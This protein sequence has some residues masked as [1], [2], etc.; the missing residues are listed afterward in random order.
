[1]MPSPLEGDRSQI[2]KALCLKSIDV[3][4]WLDTLTTKQLENFNNYIKECAKTGNLSSMTNGHVEFIK[5]FEALTA[6]RL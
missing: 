5:E 2:V 6:P 4:K 3:P 1:M